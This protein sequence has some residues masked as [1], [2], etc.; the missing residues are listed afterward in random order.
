MTPPFLIVWK[1]SDGLCQSPRELHPCMVLMQPYP[2]RATLWAFRLWLYGSIIIKRDRSWLEKGTS[3]FYGHGYGS[4]A[5]TA[6]CKVMAYLFQW[7]A[8]CLT[9]LTA[10]FSCQRTFERRNFPLHH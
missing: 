5:Y 6:G 3:L 9:Y 1:Q 4:P 8:V 2:L 10:L 7:L